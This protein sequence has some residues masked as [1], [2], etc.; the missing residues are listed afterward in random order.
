MVLEYGSVMLIR[1]C[2]NLAELHGVRLIGFMCDD[3]ALFHYLGII[4]Y[5]RSTFVSLILCLS[6]F[7]AL[8]Q[9][10]IFPCI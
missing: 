1:Y 9:L 7:R 3:V 4:T 10:N 2:A 8:S 5:M 6:L